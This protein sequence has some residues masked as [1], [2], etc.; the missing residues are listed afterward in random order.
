MS[1]TDKDRPH[2]VSAEWWEPHHMCKEHTFSRWWTNTHT[3]DL[4]AEP[5]LKREPRHH[6]RSGI[7]RCCHWV[8]VWERRTMPSPPKWFVDHMWH[9]PQRRAVRDDSNRAR[10]EYRATGTVDTVH[11]TRQAKNCAHWYYW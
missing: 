1:R 6:W 9:N 5:S 7:P 11:D 4:P 8:P 3:C 2:W 10:A